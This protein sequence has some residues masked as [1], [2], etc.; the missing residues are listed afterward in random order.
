MKNKHKILLAFY[1]LLIVACTHDKS[2]DLSKSNNYIEIQLPETPIN[3]E[4]LSLSSFVD[5]FY[6]V[7]LSNKNLIGEIDKLLHHNGKIY[8]LDKMSKSII[9]YNEYGEELKRLQKIGRG[10]GEY[11]QLNDFAIDKRTDQIIVFCSPRKILCFDQN[12]KLIKESGCNP[13]YQYFVFQDNLYFFLRSYNQLYEGRIND[14]L[15]HAFDE[16]LNEIKQLSIPF[17]DYQ[18]GTKFDYDS[19]FFYNDN[20]VLYCDKY[21]NKVYGLT[22]D[23]TYLKYYF[24]SNERNMPDG[25]SLSM[26]ENFEKL[27]DYNFGLTNFYETNNALS[28]SYF[29]GSQLFA[30]AF[31]LKNKNILVY[32]H[33]IENNDINLFSWGALIKGKKDNYFTQ[34]ISAYDLCTLIDKYRDAIEKAPH[35]NNIEKDK[36]LNNFNQFLKIHKIHNIK[37]ND[38]PVLIYFSVKNA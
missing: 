3:N 10:P 1:S 19:P 20:E 4:S 29:V 21:E 16:D 15:I 24:N 2:I 26:K 28:F 17:K 18:F 7:P 11:T 14:F 25:L 23:S 33:L 5:S 31:Y 38:N 13:S 35:L 12:F 27:K 8:V 37:K 36:S 32:P 6:Y 9:I 34:I 30:T 22:K